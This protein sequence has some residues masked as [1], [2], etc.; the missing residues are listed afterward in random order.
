M[1]STNKNKIPSLKI[2]FQT[3]QIHWRDASWNYV[4]KIPDLETVAGPNSKKWP[5]RKQ[6]EIEIFKKWMKFQNPPFRG[7]ASVQNRKFS[8]EVNLQSILNKEKKNW[9]KTALKVPLNYPYYMPDWKSDLK[10]LVRSYTGKRPFC[11]PPVFKA[12]WKK[13]KGH[14]G[15]SHFLQAFLAFIS[16]AGKPNK[17]YAIKV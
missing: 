6:E 1:F 13:K 2:N 5:K 7:L 16:V 9:K 14:A 4:F 15:I 12:W 8:V 3:K 17:E 10:T 11:M